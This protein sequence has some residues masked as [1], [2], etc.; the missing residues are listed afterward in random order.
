MRKELAQAEEFIVSYHA[1]HAHELTDPSAE[2]RRA[3]IRG[4]YAPGQTVGWPV[5][6]LRPGTRHKFRVS[7]KNYLGYPAFSQESSIFATK[8]ALAV[9]LAVQSGR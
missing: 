8:G 3:A 5:L 9:L 6:G 4:L 7:G 1:A 2:V